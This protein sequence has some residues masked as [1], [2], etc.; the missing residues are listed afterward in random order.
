MPG[1]SGAGRP[2]P[3]C[4]SSRSTVRYDHRRLTG[5]DRATVAITP[6]ARR[7]IRHATFPGRLCRVTEPIPTLGLSPLEL[8][9]ALSG[10]ALIV[11]PWL[12]TASGR[13]VGRLS[14]AVAVASVAASATLAFRWVLLPLLIGVLAA[15]VLAVPALRGTPRVVRRRR[16]PAVLATVLALGLLAAGTG[17]AVALPVPAFPRPTGQYA[18]GTTVRQWTDAA[19]PESATDDPADH[20]T[21]VAQLWYPAS[22]GAAGERSRYLGTEQEA[23][24]VA[25][26]VAGYLGVPALAMDGPVRARTHALV[27]VPAA[28]GGPFPIVLFSPGLGGV[29]TQNTAWAEELASRG[30]V[31]AALD[32][33]YDSAVVVLRDGTVIGTR[34]AATGD[35]TEDRR[36][37][38]D[39]TAT[40]AADLR[41]ALTELTRLNQEAGSLRGVLDTTR[42]AV[43]GHSLGGAAALL[44]LRLDSRFTAA[45]DLDGFPR[46]PAPRQ[47]ARPV[48]ALNHPLEPG[49]SPDYLPRLDGVLKLTEADAYRLEVPGTAHLSFTDA[50]LF[51]PPLPSLIGSLG[52]T[53]PIRITAEASAVFLDASLKG[54]SDALGARLAALGE[55]TTYRDGVRVR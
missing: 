42:A 36:R 13:W 43:T 12:P 2:A 37:A 19:R 6:R 53:E 45:I 16:W 22:A 11:S 29:R 10:V 32:H 30:Y 49:E 15:L 55:L 3:L 26:G 39:W 20:R 24:A 1:P 44:A 4:G 51:L 50:P 18:V 7:P 25:S 23:S 31:V 33:P 21:V 27:D 48:L 38:S 5:P 46:D 52:R 40:R 28:V 54:R 47:L 35:D 34:V 8:L 17:A 9:A 14:A 41:F